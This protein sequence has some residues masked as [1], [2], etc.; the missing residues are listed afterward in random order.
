MFHT[1]IVWTTTVYGLMQGTRYVLLI[2]GYIRG[3]TMKSN[4]PINNSPLTF[5]PF[6]SSSSGVVLPSYP[7]INLNT[8]LVVRQTIGIIK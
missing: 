3:M 5:P 6:S 8:Q 7:S 2:R 4:D 1:P